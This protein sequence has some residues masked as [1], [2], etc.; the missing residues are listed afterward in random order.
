MGV[1]IQSVSRNRAAALSGYDG[2]IF[3]DDGKP[4]D[5]VRTL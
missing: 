4:T 3:T 1:H 5:K 2:N